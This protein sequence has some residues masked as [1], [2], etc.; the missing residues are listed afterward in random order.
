MH[1]A[2]IMASGESGGGATYLKG[3][4]PELAKLSVRSCLFTEP[5]TGLAT[6]L[7]ELGFSVEPIEV[8]KSRLSLARARD[9][10]QRIRSIKPDIVHAHGTRAAFY[11]ALGSVHRHSRVIYTAHGIAFRE[12]QNLP[13]RLM[14]KAAETIA[15]RR[16]VGLASVSE[17][18]LK[19]LVSLG[20][21]HQTPSAYIPNAV[22]P[23]IFKPGDKTLARETLDLPEDAFVIGTVSR[24]VEQKA[25]DVLL[26]AAQSLPGSHLV[27]IGEGPLEMLLRKQAA[28]SN[29]TC[30]FLGNRNDVPDILPALDVFVL[31]SLWEGEPLSL[32]EAMATGLPVIASDT[33]GSCAILRDEYSGLIVSRGSDQE[34]GD[35]LIKVSLDPILR[36][37]LAR[38]A[39]AA[40]AKRTLAATALKTLELYKKGLV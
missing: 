36:K 33:P 23:K 13:K 3:L 17:Q 11:C 24:L 27:I 29:V 20:Q 18:D 31:S 2:H 28:D 38:G 1:V 6:E 21:N 9:L 15:T 22:D 30:H 37:D 10:S 39:S 14:M 16:L 25:V 35:A 5:Q 7:K 12:S 4:L 19:T 40:A 34:L 32:L 8:M 26:R